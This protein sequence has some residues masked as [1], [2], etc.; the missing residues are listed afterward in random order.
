MELSLNQEKAIQCIDSNLQI[1]AC[2]GSGKTEVITRRLINLIINGVK[3]EEIVAFTFTN[4]AAENMR[5]RVNSLLKKKG[6]Q[7]DTES[8]YIG[9]IHGFCSEILERAYGEKGRPRVLNGCQERLLLSKNY[10]Q[11]GMKELNLNRGYYNAVFF[12][13]CIEKMISEYNNYDRWSDDAKAAYNQYLQLLK[14]NNYINFSFLVYEARELIRTNETIKKYISGI[15]HLIVDEYQDVDDLQESLIREISLAGALVCVVGDDDQTIYQFRGSNAQNMIDFASN[16]PN[17][18]TIELDTNYRCAR[19]VIGLAETIIS[20]NAKRLPKMMKASEDAGEGFVSEYKAEDFKTEY[21]ALAQVI[22]EAHSDGIEYSDIAV[23]L[24]SRKTLKSIILTFDRL[25]IPYSVESTL[26]FFESER[27][28]LF[29]S[30][31]DYL[32]DPSDN[33]RKTFAELWM[34]EVERRKLKNGMRFLLAETGGKR[35]FKDLF[36]IFIDTTGYGEKAENQV[37]I[38]AFMDILQDFDAIYKD[39]SWT[40]RIFAVDYYLQNTAKHEYKYTSLMEE[41][42]NNAVQIMTIHKSKGLQFDTVFIPDIQNGFFPLKTKGGRKYYTVLGDYFE[43]NKDKYEGDIEDER[44]MLYVAITRAKRYTGL[45]A[46]V[47]KHA[48]TLFLDEAE[49]Y[50]KLEEYSYSAEVKTQEIP[51]K[52][53]IINNRPKAYQGEDPYFFISYAHSDMKFADQIITALQKKKFHLWYDD[54]I[55]LGGRWDSDIAEHIES[56][57]CFLALISNNYLQSKNCLNELDFARDEEKDIIMIYLE[58]AQLPSG[59]RMRMNMHQAALLYE[60]GLQAVIERILRS[61]TVKSQPG[62]C[63]K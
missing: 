12:T 58:E 5:M 32:N 11:S 33:N 37:F 14:E 59:M 6:I 35:A 22:R 56:C 62:L 20:N 10:A 4:K 39:V 47:G 36:K 2:A 9:T 24:R 48:G 13:E 21:E 50:N 8:M 34:G 16:Y 44:K 54:G 15:Q 41:E 60:E 45:F 51:V 28:F 23:L 49:K 61:G 40:N 27:Y 17:V 18:T 42:V 53:G 30:I 52:T 1:V 57:A 19:S 25:G 46:N 29:C 3:P 38:N 43:K 31:F 26:A 7:I 55:E 63:D